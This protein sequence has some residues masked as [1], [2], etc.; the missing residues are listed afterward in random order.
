MQYNI[1]LR[2][3]AAEAFGYAPLIR[4]ELPEQPEQEGPS[5][6]LYGTPLPPDFEGTGLLGLPVFARVEFLA[7]AG[8]AQVVLND[9]IV[10]IS[11]DKLIVTTEI[12]GRD[13][14]VKEFIS[15]GDYAVTIKGVLASDPHDG[16]YARRYPTREVQALQAI[17]NAK[18]ALPVTGRLFK[19]LGIRNLVIKGHSWPSLPG[20]TNLQA[21]ELRCLSD[22][23][24][25]LQTATLPALGFAFSPTT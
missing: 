10:E 14:T 8:W 5:K 3:L 17:I 2:A 20:F 19:L 16:R 25:E 1:N 7:A 6:E 24:I 21:Y 18:E 15:N 23:A 13:G 12:E 9:P 4:Y 22:E 11:R